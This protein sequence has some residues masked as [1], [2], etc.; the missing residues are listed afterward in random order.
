MRARGTMVGRLITRAS[1]PQSCALNSLSLTSQIIMRVQSTMKW[2]PVI[3][4]S[5]LFRIKW[6]L[7]NYACLRSV[8]CV[9]SD[10]GMRCSWWATL[11]CV[12]GWAFWINHFWNFSNISFSWNAVQDIAESSRLVRVRGVCQ[13][14]MDQTAT[15][16]SVPFYISQRCERRTWACRVIYNLHTCDSFEFIECV[17]VHFH[18]N[19]VAW[20]YFLFVFD[21]H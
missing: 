20:H 13:G 14:E 3:Y 21:S 8:R 2:C 17:P 4:C 1:I 19:F 10:S 9:R 12:L 16:R 7:I 18:N 11:R 5:N 6:K 15:L